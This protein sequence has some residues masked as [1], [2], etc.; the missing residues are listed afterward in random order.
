VCKVVLE[1]P[2]DLIWTDATEFETDFQLEVSFND[3]PFLP[4]A[5][6][7]SYSTRATGMEYSIR[8]GS[9]PYNSDYRFRVRSIN[10]DTGR[11]STWSLPSAVCRTPS[12]PPH[13]C[14]CIQGQLYMQGRSDHTGAAVYYHGFPVTQT[15]A[16]GRFKIC[17][18]PGGT[19]EVAS[20][21][22]CYLEARH[23]RVQAGAGHTVTM[24]FTALRGGDVNND[25]RI[26]LFDL[27][28]VGADY[29]S[30]PP[31][32]A[33]ADCN[34]DGKINLF[35]L[36]MV[37]SN[38]GVVGPTAWGTDLTAAP[39]APDLADR[40][41]GLSALRRETHGPA[42]GA[43]LSLGAPVQDEDVLRVPIVV[44]G[45]DGLYGVDVGL[46][47]DPAKL[48]PVD[49]VG[50][51]PGMQIAP[52]D[53]WASPEGFVVRNEVRQREGQVAFVASRLRPATEVSGDVV[54][55]EAVFRVV[56]PDV[57]DAYMLT[58]A[59]LADARGSPLDVRWTGVDIHKL[60]RLFL[61]RVLSRSPGD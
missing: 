26:D 54:V 17:G 5:S 37:G 51:E 48:R 9:V 29:G 60:V 13:Q 18:V 49:Q 1:D 3:S 22:T 41:G 38:Y 34:A 30:E 7:R 20:R 32:D 53:A 24:P 35:D 50:D 8:T 56:E 21:A 28:R 27:V 61:P 14:G 36:V 11:T 58:R 52:G 16:Q 45:T 23:D 4:Y 31:R 39:G 57:D 12:L 55:A 47:Y 44:R 33:E 6:V 10:R 43:P 15:D 59:V 46:T 2:L 19:H 25:A 40:P 42:D